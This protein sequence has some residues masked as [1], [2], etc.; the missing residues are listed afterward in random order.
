MAADHDKGR[1]TFLKATSAT[2]GAAALAGL[3]T[4]EAVAAERWDA[5]ADVVVVGYGGAGACASI[6]AADAGASVIILEKQ[7]QAKHY[8]NTRMSGGLFHSP[9]PEGNRAA[10]KEYAKAMMSGENIPGKLEGEQPEVS[11]ELAA[12][13]AESAPGNLRFLQTID[14][15][16][17]PARSG[18]P[19]FPNFPGAR[20]SG[21]RVYVSSYTG[22]ADDIV[23][24]D[25]PKAEKMN[26]EAF[27]ACL[28]GG[29]ANRKAIRV[30][31]ETPASRL[32]AN[33][34]GE[35][36]GVVARQGDKEITVKARRAV[37]L[38]A[39]GYEYNMAMRKAFLEGP[40]V[41]GW[42]FYGTPFNTGDGIEMALRVGAG[43]MKVGKA[44][45]RII[46]AVPIRVNGMK[47]GLHT[48]SVGAPNSLVIDNYGKRYASE[49]LVTVDPSR[50]FFYKTAIQFDIQ[51]L[52]YPRTPSW[53]IFDETLRARQCITWLGRGT[54]GFD[55]V[56]WSKDNLDAINRGWILKGDTI[57]ELAA[58][59]KAHGD[60]RKLL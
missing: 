30:L 43:L 46:A 49:T 31:F 7:T 47:M 41:D 13:Y 44:A 8:P 32:V 9:N 35:V 15:A 59:I 42:A 54:A 37:I 34:K 23:T 21:Y 24:K 56:P 40:G 4:V 51:K 3:T 57:E 12:A 38:T 26:G 39:G 5:T 53:M 48:D 27:Y 1:R 60:N 19:A 14:P 29:V 22:K 45:S 33:D 58:K 16:F 52:D 11:D 10:L 55:F 2:A 50:Y 6:A 36:I 17:N 18:G 28:V 20:E 25:R